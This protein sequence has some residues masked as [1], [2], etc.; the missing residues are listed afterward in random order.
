MLITYVKEITVE[1]EAETLEEAIAKV[2]AMEESLE[3]AISFYDVSDKG[4]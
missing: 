2:Q 3:F 1:V 4:E